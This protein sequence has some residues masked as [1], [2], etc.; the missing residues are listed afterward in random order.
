MNPNES[1]LLEALRKAGAK[2]L[3]PTAATK[4]AA[5][6]KT[7]IERAFSD[8]RS[9][10]LVVGPITKGSGRY[11]FEP[12]R[13]PSSAKAQATIEK[14]LRDS[15]VKLTSRQKLEEELKGFLKSFLLDALSA[16]KS[17]S[18]I[19]EF[20][21]TDNKIVYAHREPILEL[22]QVGNEPLPKEES[23][24]PAPSQR[25]TLTLADVRPAYEKLKT[26]Q[27]GIS[28]VRIYDLLE[29]T[30]VARDDLHHV[31]R[32]EARRGRVSLHPATTVNFPR[33]VIEAGIRIEGER[34][35]MVTVV[36][37]ERA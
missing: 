29:A 15:G 30:R 6:S 17:E 35:P 25:K 34:D 9:R 28:V 10:G 27:G 4:E 1:N 26:Q 13:A 12:A 37:K 31:L 19:V 3:S 33:E 16:L 7:E 36:F 23:G 5:I 8:L 2:G 24:S 18:K 11:Y 20:K 22:L 14:I 21:Q 32:E